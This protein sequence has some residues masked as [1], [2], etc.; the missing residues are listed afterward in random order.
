[1]EQTLYVSYRIDSK[2]C[3]TPNNCC[4]WSKNSCKYL[5]VVWELNVGSCERDMITGKSLSE[6]LLFEEHGE[7]MLCSEIVLN[8]KNNFCAQHVLPMF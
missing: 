8:V 2:T 7:K 3:Q 6:P 1:M 5:L 4:N